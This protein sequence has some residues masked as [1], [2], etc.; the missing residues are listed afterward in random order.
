MNNWRVRAHGLSCLVASLPWMSGG[1]V[2]AIATV[3]VIIPFRNRAQYIDETIHSVLAQTVKPLEIIIIN[4]DSE[5][6]ARAHLD[7]WAKECRI[8]DLER[9]VGPSAARNEGIRHARGAFIA[10]LD[11]DDLWLPHKL[12]TQLNYMQEH[13]HCAVVCGKV[14]TLSAGVPDSLSTHLPALW[15]LPQALSMGHFVI[16]STCLV[17]THVARALK[18]FD[19]G[20]RAA[21]DIDFAIRCCASGYR[22][23]SV[24]EPLARFRRQGHQRITKRSWLLFWTD[25]KLCW[26]H[27]ALFYE[28]FG[29]RGI[30]SFLL[31]RLHFATRDTRLLDGRVRFLMRVLKVKYEVRADYL[32]AL[33]SSV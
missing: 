20:L 2:S 23:E 13:P 11:D 7:R 1:V 32:A 9:N 18:G 12:E 6:S 10:F 17:R 25:A 15:T 8:V 24:A 16:L 4:D 29:V 21:E 28:V 14:W 22:I 3:S 5:R 19:P 27:R 30:I 31:E 33:G 26:K